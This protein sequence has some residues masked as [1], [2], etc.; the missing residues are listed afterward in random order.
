MFRNTAVIDI[1]IL[2]SLCATSDYYFDLVKDIAEVLNLNYTIEKIIDSEVMSKYS[3]AIGCLYGYC[4][5]CNFVNTDDVGEKYTPAL[6][7][8][9]EL[10]I[11][12]CFPEKE[13]F[14][15]ILSEYLNTMGWIQNA[16]LTNRNRFIC[17]AQVYII[18]LGIML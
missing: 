10:K 3:V 12:S 11:Y 9:G 1:K 8:N 7:I 14:K 18:Y 4:P 5:G 15:G 13:V 6:V 16:L 2:G 17:F